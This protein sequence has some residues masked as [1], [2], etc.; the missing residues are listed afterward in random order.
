VAR[1][2]WTYQ[3]APAGAPAEGLEEYVV[4]AAAGTRVGKVQALLR[5]DGE[6]LLAI[7]RGNPPL[8]HDVRAVPWSAVE[9]VDHEALAVRLRLGED[10][11]AQALELDPEKGVEDE[12]AE[13]VRVTELPAE[14]RPSSDPGQ[15]AGPVDRPT[16]AVSLALGA[17]GLVSFLAVVIALTA[18]DG[19]GWIPALFVIPAILLAAAGAAAYRVFREPYERR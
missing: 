5:R 9:R 3:V 6:L 11:V 8:T 12:D 16:Y 10:A 1:A 14:L 2:E 17:L 19:P 13:A 7:D 4:E 18:E 15:A